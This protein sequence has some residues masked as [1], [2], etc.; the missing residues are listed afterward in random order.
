MKKNSEWGWKIFEAIEKYSK[1][2]SGGYSSIHDIRRKDNIHFSDKMETFFLAETL[3]YLYLLF[4]STEVFPLDKYVFNTEAHPFP[5]FDP[6]KSLL[7]RPV[8]KAEPELESKASVVEDEKELH[9]EERLPGNHHEQD[10][11]DEAMEELAVEAD[12]VEAEEVPEVEVEYEETSE[13]AAAA[14]EQE[15]VAEIVSEEAA[16]V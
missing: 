1:V 5:I 10:A 8:V 2:Q 16:D 11:V 12:D 3:K 13:E 4:G 15:T 14:V 7:Q 6:P 9:L